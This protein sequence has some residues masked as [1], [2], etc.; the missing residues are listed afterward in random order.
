MR[1]A[2]VL[3]CLLVLPACATAQAN[4][5]CTGN[6]P[7]SAWMAPAPVYRDCEVDRKARQ[8]GSDPKLDT[9]LLGG[10]AAS[11][12]CMR[13]ELEFVVDTAGLP[14]PLTVRKKAG[15]NPVLERVVL[16]ALPELRYV[17]ARLGDQPVRQL[18]VYKR[19]V[20]VLLSFVVTRA[21]ELPT[22]PPPPPT[23]GR[24]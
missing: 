8:R 23:M 9:E 16:D 2:L 14:E 12:G 19:A 13:V 18:V 17:P 11:N 10:R 3:A 21:G 5:H 22:A 4:G 15:N 20:Q 1:S 7:D 6:P 24:C